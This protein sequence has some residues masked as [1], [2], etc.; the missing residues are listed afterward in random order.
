MAFP[1]STRRELFVLLCHDVT[2]NLS[3]SFT[4]TL[5]FLHTKLLLIGQSLLSLYFLRVE[6]KKLSWETPRLVS[7]LWHVPLAGCGL[8]GHAASVSQPYW[9][10]QCRMQ[11]G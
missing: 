1:P 7:T 4:L 3:S 6:E 11:L 8:R 10:H 2:L 9:L 5:M